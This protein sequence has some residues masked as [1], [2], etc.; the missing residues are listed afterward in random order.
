M[1]AGCSIWYP[2]PQQRERLAS[3]VAFLRA[4]RSEVAE[5]LQAR[6]TVP[7]MPSGV[8][9]VSWGL[10]QAPVLLSR[11]S[12]IT[13][14]PAFITSTL[15]QLEAALEGNCWRAGNWSV[16]DLV[17]R[18]EEAGVKLELLSDVS[19]VAPDGELVTYSTA[20]RLRGRRVT[21]PDTL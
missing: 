21:Y 5:F 16:R 3:Q 7:A 20:T 2:E 14:V 18:L 11:Y 15:R 12:V 19:A 13:D 1:A 4:H 10:K 6:D 9:L 8:R 17:E